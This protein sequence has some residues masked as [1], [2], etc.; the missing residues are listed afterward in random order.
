MLSDESVIRM[1]N[2][3]RNRKIDLSLRARRAIRIAEY[4]NSFTPEQQKYILAELNRLL[5]CFS[6]LDQ[7]QL[8]HAIANPLSLAEMST[9]DEF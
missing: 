5:P 9:D 1:M 7:I 8:R 6:I 2:Y 3:V 4:M